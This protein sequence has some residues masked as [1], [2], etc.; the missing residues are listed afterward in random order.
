M[1]YEKQDDRTA[2][3]GAVYITNDCC[4][5]IVVRN[6][7]VCAIMIVIGI[8][9]VDIVGCIIV[10]DIVGCII[11]KGWNVRVVRRGRWSIW[12]NPDV[13]KIGLGGQQ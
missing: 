10:I 12:W 11:V 13:H 4:A 3:N 1:A 6:T 8:I 5:V 2:D 9:V 7:A